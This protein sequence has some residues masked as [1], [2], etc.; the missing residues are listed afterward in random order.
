MVDVIPG[1]IAEGQLFR[2]HLARTFGR[3]PS[4]IKT[5]AGQGSS[6]TSRPAVASPGRRRITSA[7]R[8][9]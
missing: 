4:A 7:V 1:V 2:L 8:M 5:P 6:T 9:I 3:Q